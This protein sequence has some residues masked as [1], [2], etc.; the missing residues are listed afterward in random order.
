MKLISAQIRDYKC[1]EDSGS[2]TIGPVTC[3]VGKNESGKTAI[4]E[5]LHKLKPDDESKF[6][7][8]DYPRRKWQ[9][10]MDT[11]KLPKNV[12]QTEWEIEESDIEALVSSFGI[13]PLKN[14]SVI[15][16]CSYEHKISWTVHLEE[17]QL[18]KNILEHANLSAPE[19]NKI[20]NAESVEDI[21]VGLEGVEEKSENQQELLT[22]LKE[23]YTRGTA[24][25]AVIDLLRE[26]LPHFLYFNEYY[27]LPG[28]VALLD[29]EKRRANSQLEHKDQVFEALLSLVG[30]STKAIK[31]ISTFDRMRA[32]LEAVSNRLS[33]E[34]FE[35]WSQNSNLEVN[36]SFDNARPD[37]PIPFNN[38]YIF[39]TSIRNTRHKATVS[40]D[41][42]SSGFVWFFSFLVWFSQVRE[43]YG[44][45]LVILLDE[46]ALN[47]HARAQADLLRYI[48][49][50][51][52]HHHQ[53]IYTTHSPF[54]I[55]PD[56]LE[57]TRTVE[58]VVKVEMIDGRRKDRLLGTKVSEDV[59][60]VD[61]DT[62]SPLQGALGYDI[63]Q[64]LFVGKNTLLVEGPSDLIFMKWLSHLLVQRNRHG[65]SN[66]WT[67]CPVGGIDKI[68]SFAALFG[69]NALRI[70]VVTD[71]HHG[72]KSKVRSLKE[73]QLLKAGHVFTA[74][75]YVKG[76]EADI[77]DVLGRDNYFAIVDAA[78]GLGD[79]QTMK[80]FIGD[81]S[82]R[83]VVDVASHFACLPPEVPE[84][85]HYGPAIHAIQ[86]S[87]AIENILPNLDEALNNFEQLFKDINAILEDAG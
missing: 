76:D 26:R 27:I 78:Y 34:I 57:W 66:K 45:R 38:G 43:K 79:D 58:D 48:S 69:A 25:P 36:F 59:L 68:S 52:A 40:F 44:E 67:I 80:N 71:Y 11:S 7:D 65:L 56:K 64:T 32:S 37:D 17:K 5:A 60:A 42:R 63:T 19:S 81:S 82:A 53:V 41:D 31:D 1:I 72:E 10:N 84:Y 70:A 9:P 35:Y 12:I 14:E 33:E 6:L 21:L 28:Q 62:I 87:D 16:K 39:R 15:V 85:D 24:S 73:G 49:E 51:L 77:E 3:L 30:T 83:V 2:F 75:Q 54:M 74:D 55:D 13:N 46:P 18:V 4:L 86:N 20:R 8:L 50:R 61:R 29:F 22:T 47:L 23:Q